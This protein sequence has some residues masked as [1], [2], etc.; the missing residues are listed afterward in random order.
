MEDLKTKEQKASEMY[1]NSIYNCFRSTIVYMT[2]TIFLIKMV[3]LAVINL[4]AST[5]L[6]EITVPLI[7]STLLLI[8]MICELSSCARSKL[9]FILSEAVT[10]GCFIYGQYLTP[11]ER[12]IYIIQYVM[13]TFVLQMN[14]A[15][16]YTTFLLMLKVMFV[17]YFFPIIFCG[18]AIPTT[19]GPYAT[20][21]F[22]TVIV[23]KV[24][25]H[26]K[27]LLYE[28][29]YAN[30]KV[31]KI[32]KQLLE[33]IQALPESVILL[34]FTN[35]IMFHNKA[36]QEQF[37][38]NST[39][40]IERKLANFK[41][42]P[43][44]RHYPGEE[45]SLIEDAYHY[46]ISD[47]NSSVTFG[48][49]EYEGQIQEWRGSKCEWDGEMLVVLSTRDIT[50]LI[51]FE[52]AKDDANYKTTLLRT[53]S[54][55]IRNPTNAIISISD[56][57]LNN[58][59]TFNSEFA[60]NVRIINISSKL[61]HNLINDLL[62]FSKM[63]AECLTINKIHFDLKRFLQDTSALFTLQCKSKNLDLRLF[64]DP[65]LP[66]Y[67][68]SDPNRLRQI[69]INLIS[70]ALKFTIQGSIQLRASITLTSRLLIEVI[71]TGSGIPHEKLRDL[72]NAFNR[73]HDISLNPEGCGLGLYISNTFAKALGGSSIQVTSVLNEGSKFE[74]EVDIGMRRKLQLCEELAED[75]TGNGEREI[76]DTPRNIGFH[77]SFN[78]EKPSV[79]VLDD[80][81]FNR[82]VLGYFLKEKSIIYEQACSGSE[83]LEVLK[84]YNSTEGNI[85]LVIMDCNMPNMTGMETSVFMQRL[86]ERNE[87]IN[88]PVVVAHTGD[89]T[90]DN[91]KVCR[92][93]GMK[94]MI[95]KPISKRAFNNILGKYI[96]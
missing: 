59:T 81:E 24:H 94:E 26:K 64:I 70:N 65:L 30:I 33:V 87:I 17:W 11:Q 57:I 20:V 39:Q 42:K 91:R 48:I 4:E 83:A 67:V 62:D 58:L 28:F 92:E 14:D 77:S 41:Y 22:V 10:L 69:I 27:K 76:V 49:I 34:S 2:N 55:E 82:K 8:L 60:E 25:T 63:M 21:I 93:A 95:I 43:G 85:K 89:D 6:R 71:D 32:K 96:H 80:D 38:H 15:S 23:L 45:S 47:R 90:E 13:V 73:T 7:T 31:E 46:L 56:E 51:E 84:K 1:K 18:K 44:S 75:D 74:F 72:F 3:L 29:V 61:L 54:H 36:S 12:D 79:L 35:S 9:L 19:T 16:K 50:G 66:Q 86:Y 68:E 37:R 52:R 5:F 53:V 78:I 40:E 88:P